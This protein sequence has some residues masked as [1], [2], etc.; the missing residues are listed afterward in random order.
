MEN[1]GNYLI[2]KKP[3]YLLKGRPKLNNGI[4]IKTRGIKFI[5]KA[6]K[7]LANYNSSVKT[8]GKFI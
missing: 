6:A 8:A 3:I 1:A 5:I 7:R 4:P 2:G